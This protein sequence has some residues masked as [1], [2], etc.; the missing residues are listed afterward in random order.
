MLS[1]KEWQRDVRYLPICCKVYSNGMI[2]AVKAAKQ[3]VT[4]GAGCGVGVDVCG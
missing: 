1:Y 3:G 2:I 4:V